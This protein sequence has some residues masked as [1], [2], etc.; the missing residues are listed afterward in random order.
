MRRLG[1]YGGY[2]WGVKWVS[3]CA[4]VV[5]SKRVRVRVYAHAH[6][7]SRTRAYVRKK[8]GILSW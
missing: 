2:L 6:T 4:R 3:S 5:R 7:R 8:S 1:G